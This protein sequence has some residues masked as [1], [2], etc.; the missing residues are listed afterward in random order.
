MNIVLLD[1]RQT[2][3]ELWTISAKRQ[4]EHLRTHV[5][6]QAGDTLLIIESMKMEIEVLA[7]HDGKI[8]SINREAGQQVR[9]GQRLMVLE[10]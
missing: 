9:A 1:P 7:P 8:V 5:N 4:L 3:S 2:E 10:D 6:V